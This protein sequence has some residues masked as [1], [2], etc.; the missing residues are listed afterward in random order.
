[1][2]R[3]REAVEVLRPQGRGHVLLTSE[4]A[5]EALPEGVD[6][7]AQDE[8]LRGTH[9]AVD[10]GAA[11]L[12]RELSAAMDAPA[13]LARYSRLWADA[14]RPHDSDTLFRELAEG[15]PVALNQSLSPA[16][17]T[18]R[19]E[20]CYAPY[21]A[22]VRE[23]LAASAARVVFAIHSFT[24]VYEGERRSLALGVLFDREEELACEVAR[25]LE[26]LGQ[27]VALNEPYSGRLG[28]IYSASVHA[29]AHGC[30]AL[31][32]EVR[33]DLC[34]DASFRAELT[35]VLVRALDAWDAREI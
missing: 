35:E 18:R 33:Q 16:E 1:M 17:R 20:H 25:A 26:A 4:H 15:R 7:P 30:R 11:A 5:G 22:A 10:L 12:T 29:E 14:N 8:W 13:I 6:W 3:G 34:V 24:P 19:L 28:L 2:N 31:E 32:L 27:P 9:W 23:T 21:H